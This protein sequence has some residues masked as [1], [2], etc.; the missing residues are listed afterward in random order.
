MHPRFFYD[1]TGERARELLFLYGGKG[2]DQ[3]NRIPRITRSPFIKGAALLTLSSPVKIPFCETVVN[4]GRDRFFHISTSGQE[5]ETL[6]RQKADGTYLLRE[7]TSCEG[8]FAVSVKGKNAVIHVRIHR[9]NG[10]FGIVPKDSFRGLAD[11]LDNYVRMPMVQND[12]GVV[13][14]V[15]AFSTTRFTAATIDDR[16]DCLLRSQRKPGIKDGFV[17]EFEGLH[18]EEDAQMFISCKEGRRTENVRKN[19]YR[20]VVPFDHTRIKLKSLAENDYINAN[21]IKVPL[22]VK[23]YPEFGEFQRDYISTQGCL[24]ETVNDFWQM[25]WQE[26][27]RLI[28]MVTKEV[29]RGRVKCFRYWPDFEE[30]KVYGIKRLSVKSLQEQTTG[31]YVHRLFLL[32][33]AENEDSGPSRLVHHFQIL[34]WEDNESCPVGSVLRFLDSVNDCVLKEQIGEQGPA[35]VHCSAGIGRTG[36]YIALDILTNCIRRNGPQCVCDVQKTVRMLREQRA[37]M[38]QTEAQYRFIY[39]VISAFMKSYR[40]IHT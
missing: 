21:Y 11:L 26:E 38:V 6:L 10:R 34:G 35:V 29:E 8:E 39:Y 13:K 18:R 9:R 27:S 5:A 2:C 33:A 31:D 28:V 37:T 25:V 4:I 36:T 14:L 30:Q 15:A 22:D 40:N 12:G 7:S 19:R 17:D 20:N 3:A 32:C 24:E 16:I 1:V 23:R